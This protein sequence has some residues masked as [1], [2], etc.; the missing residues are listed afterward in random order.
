MAVAVAQAAS[1]A[2]A[3]GVTHQDPAVGPMTRDEA[4]QSKQVFRFAPATGSIPPL[5]PR[6]APAPAAAAPA[7]S[8]GGSP[9]R[10]IIGFA[11]YWLLSQNPNWNYSLLTTVAYFGLGI[12]ANGTLEQADQ[13]WSGWNSQDL[14]NVITAAHLA[15]DRVVAVIKPSNAVG[16]SSASTVNQIVTSSSST[17][18]AIN[19]AM[20]AIAARNLDGVNVDFEGSS[21]G[22][23]NAQAGFTN[24]MTQL[25]QQVHQRFPGASVTADTYSGS[26]SWDGGIFKIGDLAPVVDYLFVMAYDMSFSNMPGGGGQAGPNAPLNG[27]TYNDTTA[28]GQYLGKASPSKV[29]LGVPYYGYKW[30]TV[31]TSPYSAANRPGACPDGYPNPVADTY[32]G[33]VADFGCA[34]QLQKNW[35]TGAGSPWASWW[36]PA[37]G[38]PC[39][40]S[41]NG[42]NSWRELYYDDAASLGLKYDLVNA[43]G[44]RG[45]G[46]WA[47]GYDGASQDLWNELQVK[48]F[49]ALSSG[50]D[51]S[52]WG[53]GRLDVFAKGPDNALWHKYYAGGWSIWTSLGGQIT[54]EPAAVSWSSGRIDVFARGAN[55]DLQHIFYDASG[56]GW[57]SWYSHGG[58]LASGPDVASWGAGRLDVF[59]RGTNNDLQH[60]FYSANAGWST[61]YSHGGSLNSDAGAVSWGYGRIDVFARGAANDLQHIFYSAYTGWTTWYS[62]GGTLNSGPDVSSWG[63]GRLDVF[64]TDGS[65]ALQHIFYDSSIGSWSSWYNHGGNLTS[66]PGAVSWGPG[67]IDVFA[68]G[69]DNSLQHLVYSGGWTGWYRQ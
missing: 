10:E 21:S 56:G 36:S 68:R 19:N 13:G 65:N 64:T 14:A 59:A 52:S 27:W 43:N 28:V 18:Q 9:Q 69:S 44:L 66:D 11:P 34:L 15:G 1:A 35:D 30:C 12:H 20:Y 24:F 63:P 46:M 38:D 61:W 5:Q 60:I 41:G 40:S 23:P 4:R 45:A 16:V 25:S 42:H 2:S 62:H 57:S 49:L 6:R 26:A 39:S 54:S 17:Q 51:V 58:N 32:S 37:T 29:V 33:V 67:R 31:D 7:A 3:G 48:F 47:L 50:A 8:G 53:P 22:Y 55:N